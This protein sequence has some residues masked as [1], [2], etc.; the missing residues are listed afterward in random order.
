MVHAIITRSKKMN[1]MIL[2]GQGELPFIRKYL[3]IIFFEFN[4][5][6]RCEAMEKI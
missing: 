6:R 5:N 3:F 1:N 4:Y 2:K